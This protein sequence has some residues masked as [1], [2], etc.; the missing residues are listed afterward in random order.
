MLSTLKQRL[1]NRKGFTLIELIVVIAII[2]ILAAVLI[3]RFASF[4]DRADE[5]AAVSTA[6]TINT[7]LAT[8]VADGVPEATIE[9][10]TEASAPIT[11]LTGAIEAGADLHDITVDGNEVGFTYE[12]AKGWEV[13]YV[14]GVQTDV[15]EPT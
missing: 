3:P 9:A 12:S 4:T 2:A 7:A 14:N 5:S 13:I 15:N 10:Y 1:R 8:L 6:K 11:D